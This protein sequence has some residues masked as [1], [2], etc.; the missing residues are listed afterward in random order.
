MSRLMGGKSFTTPCILSRNGHG[1]KTTALADTGANAL[2]P[3]VPR[4]S[5]SF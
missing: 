3:N 4:S 2:T 1:V 5:L